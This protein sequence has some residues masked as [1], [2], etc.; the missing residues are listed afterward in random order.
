MIPSI[1]HR[2][3]WDVNWVTWKKDICDRLTTTVGAMKLKKHVAKFVSPY[4]DSI[5]RNAS[6]VKSAL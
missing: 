1:I 3:N 6:Q 4:Y 2:K 5:L